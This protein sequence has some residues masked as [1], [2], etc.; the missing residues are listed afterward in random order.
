[1]SPNRLDNS[2]ECEPC[3]GGSTDT[4]V[5]QTRI[6]LAS[7]NYTTTD[8][9]GALPTIVPPYP[10]DSQAVRLGENGLP[11][12]LQHNT[13]G[14]AEDASSCSEDYSSSQE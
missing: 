14:H 9:P 7:G 8:M 2:V 12:F 11:W 3:D 4:I 1:M 5:K 13:M 6:A 10:Q